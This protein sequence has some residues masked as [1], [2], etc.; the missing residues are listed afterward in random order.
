MT[1]DRPDPIDFLTGKLSDR[2]HPRGV[3]PPGSGEKFHPDGAVQL[4]PGNTFICHIDRESDAYAAMLEIQECLMRS[5]FAKFYAFLPPPSFHMTVFQ[6][7]SPETRPGTLWPEGAAPDLSRDAITALMR[8]RTV[9]LALP[10][11]FRVSVRELFAGYS[12][13]VKGADDSCEAALRA[14]RAALRDANGLRPPDFEIYRFHITLAYPLRWLSPAVAAAVVALSTELF[15][16]NR[17]RLQNITLGPVE[18]CNFESMHHFEP[19]ARLDG[20]VR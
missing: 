19:V 2:A 16:A 14:T 15:E 3:G 11:E 5:E 20:K 9:G 7:I 12:L 4:W 8:E 13:T 10:S 17:A 1:P 18:L 6:G